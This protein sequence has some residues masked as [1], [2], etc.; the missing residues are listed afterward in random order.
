MSMAPEIAE[1]HDFR[2]DNSL[3]QSTTIYE[4]VRRVCSG[5][6]IKTKDIMDPAD[7]GGVSS[8]FNPSEKYPALLFCNGGDPRS[9]LDQFCRTGGTPDDAARDI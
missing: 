7:V 1:L 4:S 5:E 8:L 2:Q 3:L 9:T 6:Y